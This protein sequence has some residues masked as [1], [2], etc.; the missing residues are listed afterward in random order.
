M[1]NFCQLNVNNSTSVHLD[2]GVIEIYLQSGLD[3]AAEYDD[4]DFCLKE[5]G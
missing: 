2:N 1:K 4:R 3:G 5:I